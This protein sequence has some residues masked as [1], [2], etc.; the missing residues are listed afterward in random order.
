MKRKE[1]YTIICIQKYCREAG[2]EKEGKR[3]DEGRRRQK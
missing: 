1:D 2:R 3:K